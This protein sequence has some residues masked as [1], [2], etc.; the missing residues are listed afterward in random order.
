MKIQDRAYVTIAYTL[1]LDSD[2]VVD[3]SPSGE[4]LGFIFGVG[5]MIPGLEKALR[6]MEKGQNSKITVE[7]EEGYGLPNSDLIREIPRAN[8]PEGLDIQPGMGFEA[9]GPQGPMTFRVDSV[10][11]KVVVADFNHPLAG[12]RLHFDVTVDEV[13]EA[14]PEELAALEKCP[15]NGCAGCGGTCH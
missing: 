8:F 5:R 1:T 15:E 12:R 7:P 9:K 3:R 10:T 6:G 2:E 14:T 4:P 11:D 13:R